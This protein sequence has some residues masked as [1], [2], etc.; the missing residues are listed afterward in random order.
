MLNESLSLGYLPPSLRQAAIT[1]I[2]KGGKDLLQCSSYRPISLLNTDY[3]V[4]SKILST[5][6]EKV[7][8]QIIS[9]DQT[10][11]ILNGHSSS[12]LRRL[13]NIVYSSPSDSP[14][15]AIALDA[16]KA[17]DRVEWQYLFFTLK[18]FGL[19]DSFISWIKLLYSHPMA[20]V[21]TNGQRSEFFS[22][23]RGTRQGCSLSPLLFA[24]AIE[25]LAAALR[26]SVEFLGIERGGISHK[27]SLYADD[28][29]LYVADPV[30]S[31]PV[32]LRILTQF[33]ELSG[34][35][36]NKEKSEIFPLNQPATLI[37]ASRLPFR[38]VEKG[39]KYLGIE[40]TPTFSSLFTKNFTVL[41]EKCKKDMAKW[42]KLPLSIVGRISLIK[43]IM[44]SKFIYLFQNIPI[45]IKKTFFNLLQSN[46][47]SFIWNGK[48]HRI[49]G[50]G[51]QRPKK[52]AGLA[53]PN[54]IYYYWACNI[55]TMLHWREKD[56]PGR[57]DAW[58]QMENAS[59]RISLGSVL[60]ASIP[61][62]LSQFQS[63]PV[64]YHSIRIWSQFRR[65]FKLQT[66][67]VH[68]PIKNNYNFPP[69]LSDATFGVW[70]SKGIKF[71]SNLFVEGKFGSFTQLS[72]TFDLPKSHFFLGI[73]S[74]D[75]MSRKAVRPFQISQ[76]TM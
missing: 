55:K 44:L 12:N 28:I 72:Q 67:S 3:K 36:I 24:I 53:L 6:L 38:I 4:L 45:L 75:T 52:L 1:L 71:I 46:I 32:I 76:L 66:T 13:L 54:F 41:F 26:Q 68:S 39:F 33:G 50:D 14:E 62:H 34:Y 31:I 61:P 9:P 20:S 47:L 5:R 15:M 8:S 40:I 49:K 10:G 21:I 60:C 70:S 29:I 37:P 7:I 58:V 35:K 19:D 17:F 65:N 11:F 59:S 23:N 51:L 22:L 30:N 57:L 74:L 43:M 56:E 27:I 63:N 42:A 48:P 64:V 73:F 16:E 69:S 25:P 18:T 2:P